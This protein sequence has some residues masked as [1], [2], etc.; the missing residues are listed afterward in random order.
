M[1]KLTVTYEVF[2]FVLVIISLFLAFSENEQLLFYDKLIW[3]VFVIDYIT[4]LI[5]SE[6]KW[7]Y[8]K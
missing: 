2:M 4:R 3:V 5:L 8:I 6:K 1:K 7:S